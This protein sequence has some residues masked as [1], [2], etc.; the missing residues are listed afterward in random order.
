MI[1][2]NVQTSKR[3]YFFVECDLVE[4]KIFDLTDADPIIFMSACFKCIG[5]C[6]S[7]NIHLN[8]WK[9]AGK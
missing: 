2:V 7:E 6:R 3:I 1:A 4:R 8:F 5:T 9:R